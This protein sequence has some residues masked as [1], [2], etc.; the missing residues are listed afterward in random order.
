MNAI[1]SIQRRP[2][3]RA[4][5]AALVAAAAL[6]LA[7]RATPAFA[8]QL[9][10]NVYGYVADE[11]GGRLPGVTVTLTGPGAPKSQTSDARGEYRFLN[12]SPGEYTLTYELQGLREADQDQRAGLGR[13]EHRDERGAQAHQRRGG[14]DRHRRAASSRHAAGPDRR[15]H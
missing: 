4:W 2:A 3:A 15:R 8:Q 12:L 14:G 9:T 13:P 10:G 5:L 1:H 11:Q 6:A 7:T